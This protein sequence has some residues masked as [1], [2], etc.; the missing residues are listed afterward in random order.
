MNSDS[1]V[2]NIPGSLFNVIT[3][4]I[5]VVTKKELAQQQNIPND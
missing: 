5:K 3:S 1:V 2:N 4:S